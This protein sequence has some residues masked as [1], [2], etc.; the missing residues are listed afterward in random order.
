[1]QLGVS[2]LLSPQI[3]RGGSDFVDH[4][5]SVAALGEIYALDVCLAGVAAL[6]ADVRELTRRVNR[7]LLVIFFSAVWT[8]DAAEVP[9]G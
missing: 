3:K 2:A 1:M 7:K 4:R 8:S 5:V 6:D 9:F